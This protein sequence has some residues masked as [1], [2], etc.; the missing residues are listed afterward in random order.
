[1][2]GQNSGLNQV[3]Y[4]AHE[5]ELLLRQDQAV[6]LPQFHTISQD[7][8]NYKVSHIF[9]QL[10]HFQDM[11]GLN[12]YRHINWRQYL[13]LCVTTNL[14]RA[15]RRIKAH[16]S[17][18][19]AICRLFHSLQYVTTP[20]VSAS[21]TSHIKAVIQYLNHVQQYQPK[22]FD[23]LP[24]EKHLAPI[25]NNLRS[26]ARLVSTV[27]L[28]PAL[29][30]VPASFANGVHSNIKAN[31]SLIATATLAAATLA[32]ANYPV[33]L[34]DGGSKW[35]LS[36]NLSYFGGR[37][38]EVQSSDFFTWLTTLEGLLY[39]CSLHL[40][41]FICIHNPPNHDF[42]KTVYIDKE[43]KQG[44]SGFKPP[45]RAVLRGMYLTNYVHMVNLQADFPLNATPDSFWLL[46]LA[47]KNACSPSPKLPSFPSNPPSAS[48][49][50]AE[51][52]PARIESPHYI[53]SL[54]LPSIT[55]SC[56]LSPLLCTGN[57]TPHFFVNYSNIKGKEE[58]DELESGG[59]METEED[60]VVNLLEDSEMR[61]EAD[62]QTH[63][64]A[65]GTLVAV[66]ALDPVATLAEHLSPSTSTTLLNSN[67]TYSTNTTA[68][69]NS[70]LA[71]SSNSPSLNILGYPNQANSLFAFDLSK[72][73]HQLRIQHCTSNIILTLKS[74]RWYLRTELAYSCYRK[75]Q[76]V[77]VAE[78][79]DDNGE[80]VKVTTKDWVTR[81]FLCA[82]MLKMANGLNKI[83][84][85]TVLP[86]TSHALFPATWVRF[87]DKYKISAN[88]AR[89]DFWLHQLDFE[90]AKLNIQAV[91]SGKKQYKIPSCYQHIPIFKILDDNDLAESVCN[92]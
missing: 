85:D 57:N 2:L 81:K 59:E 79:D 52:S 90:F 49:T 33:S 67:S 66:A 84:S 63:R 78:D 70:P 43:E 5:V 56:L 14:S 69:N 45:F 25:V 39:I 16:R 29:D 77:E 3:E 61:W 91:L 21:T 92:F 68:R 22:E 30:L 76:R 64:S 60:L 71:L 73:S 18:K 87:L 89:D 88:I 1:M 86:S 9:F 65:L 82:L 35:T 37:E 8:V 32:V 20:T 6:D 10:Y 54:P 46:N 58:V 53:S 42:T 12:Y 7:G 48:S 55:T 44:H 47:G 28:A 27:T 23:P 40:R 15:P 36:N 41:R 50:S 17:I 19:Q 62:N 72:A 51:G 26:Y 31:Y 83:A 38:E 24:W 75:K 4:S 11:T 74:R 13:W 80:E 34:D